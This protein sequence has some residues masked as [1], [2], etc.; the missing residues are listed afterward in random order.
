MK[1]AHASGTPAFD[2]VTLEILWRRA[3]SAVDEAAK[4]LARTS[5]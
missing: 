1:Q 3:I 5:F 4:A 2:A